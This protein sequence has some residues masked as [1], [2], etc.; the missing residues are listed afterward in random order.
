MGKS[1]QVLGFVAIRQVYN[2]AANGCLTR[3]TLANTWT[4]G[5][6]SRYRYSSERS[7]NLQ[8]S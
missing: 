1:A 5:A 4:I 3:E 2:Q 7:R 8:I 6:G